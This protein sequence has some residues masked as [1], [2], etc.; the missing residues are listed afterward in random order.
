MQFWCDVLLSSL[1]SLFLRE[2]DVGVTLTFSSNFFV[3]SPPPKLV[4]RDGEPG[5]CAIQDNVRGPR[6]L[7]P[8][9]LDC[10]WRL[11]LCNSSGRLTPNFTKGKSDALLSSRYPIGDY[12]KLLGT[13]LNFVIELE[14]NN[15]R[16]SWFICLGSAI[17]CNRITRSLLPNRLEQT[18][19][20]PC[21]KN[22]SVGAAQLPRSSA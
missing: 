13:P 7:A 17:P 10:T 5:G 16:L 15:V 14:T 19:N 12:S 1:F 9:P 20:L 18:W 8:D 22:G 4:H 21:S 3:R 11:S 2:A 6:P